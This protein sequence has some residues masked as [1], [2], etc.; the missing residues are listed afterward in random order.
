VG[1]DTAKGYSLTRRVSILVS[2]ML[3]DIDI[4]TPTPHVSGIAED[5]PAR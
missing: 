2:I 5:L 4:V 3:L 1:C